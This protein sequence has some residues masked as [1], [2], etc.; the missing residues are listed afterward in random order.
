MIHGSF[1][2][3]LLCVC[4][5]V[6]RGKEQV[7]DVMVCSFCGVVLR[8][9]LLFAHMREKHIGSMS[10]PCQFC[11]KVFKNRNSLRVH[12]Y[13]FHRGIKEPPQPNLE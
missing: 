1:L 11:G 9:Q 7:P 4:L 2:T 8:R 3:Q 13:N 6:G 5:H 10:M 12:I